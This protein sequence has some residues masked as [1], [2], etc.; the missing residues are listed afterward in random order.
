[1]GR[2]VRLRRVK[3]LEEARRENLAALAEEDS[4]FVIELEDPGQFR[5]SFAARP[6]V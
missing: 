2:G 5:G 4:L 6:A 1:M 3:V